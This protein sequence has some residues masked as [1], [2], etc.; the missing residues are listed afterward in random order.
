[1]SLDSFNP[2]TGERVGQ[3]SVTPVER[4]PVL[5]AAARAA[6]AQCNSHRDHAEPAAR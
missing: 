6:P 1:M 5:V 3:V 2:A 4:V